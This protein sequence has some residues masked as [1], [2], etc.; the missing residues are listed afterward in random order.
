MKEVYVGQDSRNQAKEALDLISN[1]VAQTLGP[2]GRPILL[3]RT[4]QGAYTDVVHTKDGVTVL[5]EM[6]YDEPVFDAVH[7]LC[8]QAANDTVAN[9]GD[10]TTSTLI[11]A[12]AF[13]D[14]LNNSDLNPQA[15]IRKYEEEIRDAIS[16]IGEYVESGFEYEEMVALTSCNGDREL[17]GKIMEAAGKTSSH[18]TIV[19][20][21]NHITKKRYTVEKTD[22]YKAGNGYNS[23]P[24]SLAISVADI[25]RT[26][27]DF[28]LEDCYVVPFNGNLHHKDQIEKIIKTI[29][30]DTKGKANVL[31]VAYEITENVINELIRLN[32]GEPN[33]KVMC[34]KTTPTAE[35][36]GAWNQLNDIAA[37]SGSEILDGGLINNFKTANLGKVKK[38]KVGSYE[39]YLMGRGINQWIVERAEQNVESANKAPTPLDKAIIESRNASLTGGL[40]KLVIGGGIPGN[41]HE[42]ADRAEDAIK[43]VQACRRSGAVPGCGMSY[44]KASSH[45]CISKEVREALHCIVRTILSNHGITNIDCY[46]DQPTLEKPLTLRIDEQGN[47]NKGE[48]KELGVADSFETVKSVI[49]NG[50]ALGSLIAGLGGMIINSGLKEVRQARIL[51]EAMSN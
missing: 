23:F 1:V 12:S 36:N 9:A 30:R 44:V 21:K 37:F 15:A 20:E 38:A 6:S 33:F 28:Y 35:L 14:A 13:A 18:G 45:A 48:L 49:L 50:F 16:H 24:I 47:V 42:I 39:T 10:G 19:V 34:A 41:I 29:Y 8:L 4:G 51:K 17:A 27:G 5:R 3:T 40:V 2:S 46:L 7:K 11:M 25:A 43:S 22:G 26:N 32:R 31:V